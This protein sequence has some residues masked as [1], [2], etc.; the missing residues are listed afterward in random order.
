MIPASDRDVFRAGVIAGEKAG[1]GPDWVQTAPAISVDLGGRAALRSVA[2][3]KAQ[4]LETVTHHMFVGPYWVRVTAWRDGPS[5]WPGLE[6]RC[7][8]SLGMHRLR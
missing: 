1:L 5:V 7:A 2:K 3:L 4:A 8:A 6:D